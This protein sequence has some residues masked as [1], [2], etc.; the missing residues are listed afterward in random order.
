MESWISTVWLIPCYSLIGAGLSLI[1]T[2]SVTRKTGPRPAGY[3]NIF[4]TFLALV[5]AL[6]A[7]F[8]IWEQPSQFLSFPWF[9]VTG[10][11][12]TFDVELSSLT[13]GA[14]VVIIGVNLLAQIYAVG[15]ME[16]DWG[17]ARF[18]A[19]LAIFEAGRVGKSK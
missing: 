17:W 2:P 1:W 12:L 6:I 19:L 13:I 14:M 18:Y 10:L 5:H 15:Y 4:M 7:L 16:M 3:I 11:D 8:V 9:T